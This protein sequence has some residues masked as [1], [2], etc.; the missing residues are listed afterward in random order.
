MLHKYGVR[1]DDP[2]C[3]PL[4]YMYISAI[5]K[6]AGHD[7][8]VN[9]QN[10]HEP[11]ALEGYDRIL[12]TGFED[13]LPK[14][15]RDA[16]ICKANGIRT[17]VG[18]ALATFEPE[19]MLGYID[20]VVVG[21]ADEVVCDALNQIGI[22]HGTKPDLSKI[23]YP[24][25]EGFGIAE[26]H[27]RNAIKHVGVLSSRGCPF[28]CNFCAHTCK[29]QMRD[30][31]AVMAEIDT[32]DYA[33]DIVFNDNTF[34]LSKE[35]FLDIAGRMKKPW[36]AAIRADNFD[37]EMAK[38][39]KD[40]GCCYFIVGVESFIQ[41]KLDEMN[42]KTT[43]AQ[44]TNCLDLLHKYDIEYHGNI[45]VGLPGETAEDINNELNAIPDGYNVVP[46]LVQPFVGTK[47]QTRSISKDESHY[48]SNLF[49]DIITSNNMSMYPTND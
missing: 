41:A 31:D 22:V 39:A 21:E 36:S 43:V 11:V 32:Y 17:M 16:A 45:L 47:Y 44:I 3:Y 14:I 5:L 13:F 23:P 1:L 7:V 27:K 34:N 49:S 24:D 29:P 19:K 26:Y 6:R 40:G 20:T 18:G 48:F 8:M 30:I 2:C 10:I 4:G 15:I 46:V 42:K 33:E 9:N 28:S 12:F 37:E 35:R 25:Y 38:A